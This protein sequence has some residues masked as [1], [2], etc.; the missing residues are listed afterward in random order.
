MFGRLS[1]TTAALT[2]SS[3]ML[4]APALAEDC[5]NASRSAQGNTAAA[6]NAGTWWDVPEILAELAG[7]SDAQI[8]QV[9]PVINADPRIPANFTVFY[10]PAHP[11]E[12]AHNMPDSLATNGRGIDHSDDYNTPVFQAIFQDVAIA[13]S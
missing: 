11:G 8:T 13:L 3:L 12:L 9:M 1:L 2:A 5:F 6:A 4:A 7:L 10:N